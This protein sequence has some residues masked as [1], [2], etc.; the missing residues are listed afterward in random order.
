MLTTVIFQSENDRLDLRK[1]YCLKKSNVTISVVSKKKSVYVIEVS[2][3]RK[4]EKFV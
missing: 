3:E 1:K 4:K 2:L